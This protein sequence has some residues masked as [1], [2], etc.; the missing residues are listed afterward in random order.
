MFPNIKL[1]DPDNPDQEI[2]SDIDPFMKPLILALA[3]KHPDWL[4]LPKHVYRNS[5][6]GV[7]DFKVKYKPTQEV[8][9]SI[10]KEIRYSRSNGNRTTVYT[11]RNDRISEARERGSNFQTGKLREAIKK[12]EKF[13]YPQTE[14]ELV[15]L[16]IDRARFIVQREYRDVRSS[17]EDA[18]NRVTPCMFNYLQ[19][20]WDTFLATIPD[21]TA[22]EAASKL[23]D[24]KEALSKYA[25]LEH[26]IH[27][28]TKLLTVHIVD[29]TYYSVG[30]HP[31]VERYTSD[32]L[33]ED[34]K[35]KVG[36]LKLVGEGQVITGLG[37]RVGQT[38][39]FQ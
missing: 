15:N 12:V 3:E 6:S 16:A 19:P 25:E 21:V 18:M 37:V 30:I 28:K 20:M 33:P 22:R 31:N 23:L 39:I 7:C 5:N 26:A 9:G 13:F 10:D 24:T 36:L 1:V 17:Y 38:F 27:F 14:A 35:V 11:I 2:Q 8:L 4:F 29:D 34:I 32:T